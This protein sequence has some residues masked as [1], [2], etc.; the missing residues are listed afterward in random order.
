MIP[1]FISSMSELQLCQG[2]FN[3]IYAKSKIFNEAIYSLIGGTTDIL[4]YT[5]VFDSINNAYALENDVNDE[6]HN[7]IFDLNNTEDLRLCDANNIEFLIENINSLGNSLEDFYDLS[8][9]LIGSCMGNKYKDLEGVNLIQII[10]LIKD[11]FIYIEK[12]EYVYYLEKVREVKEIEHKKSLI[13]EKL[14]IE[15]APYQQ[16]AEKLLEFDSV[17]ENWDSQLSEIAYS[18]AFQ[19]DFHSLFKLK[20]NDILEKNST[21]LS[22][23][24]KYQLEK[25]FYFIEDSLA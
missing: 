20:K 10:D 21:D 19:N 11:W 3:L 13:I 24:E 22:P 23:D 5:Y 6:L 18:K 12:T 17:R 16:L 9:T 15:I 8:E 14:E 4:D 2:N 7:K 25:F 1:Q